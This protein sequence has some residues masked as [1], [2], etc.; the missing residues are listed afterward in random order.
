MLS[1]RNI[2]IK[3]M[4]MLYSMSQDHSLGLDDTVRRYRANVQRSFDLY[5]FTLWAL[6]RTSEYAI[7]DKAKKLEK[8]LPS[9]S[10]KQFTAVLA[11]N[12]LLQSLVRN[13]GFQELLRRRKLK[14]RIDLDNIR[15][16]YQD[17][18]KT[19]E[20]LT[21]SR[22]ASHTNEE[23]TEMLLSLFKHL[24]NNEPFN[25]FLE[26]HYPNWVD[27]ESLV[28]GAVKKTIKALPVEG[29]FFEEHRPQGEAV[30]DFGERLLRQVIE[31]G[32]DLLSV[33]EPTLRN[34]DA[35]RVAVI[36]MI[37]LKMALS[38]L[39]SFPSI[40]TKVTLNEF[41]EISKQYSTDKSKD[42]INGILDRLMKQLN[43]EGKIRKQGRGLQE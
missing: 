43:K 34:W 6:V 26:D 16:F 19:E 22:Q 8:L 27:D 25:D 1:R 40:P 24:V 4:Q 14:N 10:D 17:F 13:D 23:H 21:Y 11:E 39:T 9:D 5:L 7:Q 31:E 38:E 41:V 3:V 2:R 30:D 42:F 15:T 37:L 12:E 18:A 32:D 36:D 33:I 35:D 20:Y 28:V 29:D